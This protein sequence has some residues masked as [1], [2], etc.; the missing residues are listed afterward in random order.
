MGC[1]NAGAPTGV[2]GWPNVGVAGLATPKPK[3]VEP[4][5]DGEFFAAA[6]KPKVG[7][8]A[9]A[10]FWAADAKGEDAGRLPK[11]PGDDA[12][13]AKG[14]VAAGLVSADEEA[15]AGA[16]PKGEPVVALPNGEGLVAAAP[17]ADVDDAPAPNAEVDAACLVSAPNG[18]PVVAV[19]NAEGFVAAAPKADVDDV[20]APNGE[21]DEPVLLNGDVVDGAVAPNG[22]AVAFAASPNPTGFAA[23]EPNPPPVDEEPVVCPAAGAVPKPV[24][25][26]AGAAAAVP[27]PVEPKAGAP[28]VPNDPAGVG[29]PNGDK[30][31][32]A[33]AAADWEPKARAG[34]AAGGGAGTAGVGA[35]MLIALVGDVPA[36]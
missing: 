30:F 25:P 11:A 15:A 29:T 26:N 3:P 8:V 32:G 1:P 5:P 33:G 24:D 4:K 27:K 10:G 31:A 13:V 35:I 20:P 16:V 7:V 2:L 21:V 17:K 19:P 22:D 23:N 9:D 28:G 18:D 34:V 12:V 36:T 14:E 6:P